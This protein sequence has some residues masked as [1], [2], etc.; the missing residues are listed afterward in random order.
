MRVELLP[1]HTRK[2]ALVLKA[3]AKESKSFESISGRASPSQEAI[4]PT[5]LVGKELKMR[6]KLFTREGFC[7][8]NRSVCIVHLEAQH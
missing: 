3:H 5:S 2:E 7:T 4:V 8:T 1:E 6:K